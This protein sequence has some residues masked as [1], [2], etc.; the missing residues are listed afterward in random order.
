M[1]RQQGN[2]EATLYSWKAKHGAL[3]VSEARRLKQLEEKHRKLKRLLA[4]AMLENPALKDLASGN[5]RSLRRGDGR[6]AT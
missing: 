3:T 4:E 2:S 5:F 1:C 6:H